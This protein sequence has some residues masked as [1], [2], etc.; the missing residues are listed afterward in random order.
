MLLEFFRLHFAQGVILFALYSFLGWI[1]EVIYRS[2]SAKK[3]VNAG[4]LIGPFTPV[5]GIGAAL[6]VSVSLLVSNI[7]FPLA[8]ASFAAVTVVLEFIV[9]FSVEKIF[10]F[11]LWDYSQ[12]A[13]NYKG[14]I[15][16]SFAFLWTILALFFIYLLHPLCYYILAAVP[17]GKIR[18]LSYFVLLYFAADLAVSIAALT[19]LKKKMSLLFQHY[20]DLPSRELQ[21]VSVLLNRFVNAFPDLN[22]YIE[23]NL[24]KG[25]SI[26]INE[27]LTAMKEHS[28]RKSLVK[29]DDAEFLTMVEE[30]SSNIEYQRLKT[31]QHHDSS[32]YDHIIEVAYL[33]YRISRQLN[34]DYR[35]ATRGALLHDFF[36]YDWRNHDLPDLAKNK[37]HGLHHPRIA[38]ENSEKH[39]ILNDIE[40][41]IIV[42]HMWP[43]TVIPPRYI[44]SF[45]VVFT[46]KY[47]ASKEYSIRFK[48]YMAKEISRIQRL[49]DVVKKG[50]TR[51]DPRGK[52]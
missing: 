16:P 45:V 51:I 23:R 1:I 24:G 3:F 44:E 4:F 49:A 38:L 29:K 40:R 36:C 12:N 14:I 22:L 21:K 7:P 10:K 43:L 5:Y 52:R 46:D 50:V 34:I 9:G 37:F 33:T 2:F 35:S 28:A 27:I 11:K 25:L 48:A 13:F 42:K 19:S 15:C 39:F 47:I 31:F 41:D 20:S 32:I 18:I 17:D 30:I 8:V 6:L 26:K